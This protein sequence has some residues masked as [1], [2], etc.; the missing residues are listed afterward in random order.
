MSRMALITGASAGI[1]RELARC[2]AADGWD[3]VLVARRED[4]LRELAAELE[5][6]YQVGTRVEV[7]DLSNP[8]APRQLIDR[9]Q[10]DGIALDVLVNNAG[11]GHS[12][13]FV[14]N[15]PDRLAA[16]L[17]LNMVALTLL[18][19]LVLPGMVERRRGRILNVA[20]TAAFQPG[21]HFAAYCAT[22]AYV[23]SFSEAIAAEL[24]GTGVTVTC[25]CPGATTTEFAREADMENSAVFKKGLVPMGK[26]EEVAR[27]GY[28]ACMRGRRVII[29]GLGNKAGALAAKVFPRRIVTAVAGKMMAH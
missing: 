25:L 15:D 18:T 4:K 14:E 9:L 7:C 17:Q 5:T 23:L 3:V 26:A 22:K 29:T 24:S 12:G 20:S 21:P 16:M 6:T 8:S 19:R 1:G 13:A 27:E 11:F 28:Q 10:A 2:F